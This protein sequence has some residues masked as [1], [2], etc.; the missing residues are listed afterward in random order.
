MQSL[1]ANQVINGTFGE[2]WLDDEKLAEQKGLQAKLEFTKETVDIAG[3]MAKGNKIVGWEGKGTLR[4]HKVNSRVAVK[5]SKLIKEGKN[6]TFTII[7]KLADPDSA[8]AE[9]IAIRNVS[10]DD[11]TLADFEPKKMLEVEMPFTFDD[12]DYIDI[13]N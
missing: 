10:F 3:K 2:V 4:L 7:S 11:L 8:G 12:Y 5:V 1:E 9:R 6:V 13:I